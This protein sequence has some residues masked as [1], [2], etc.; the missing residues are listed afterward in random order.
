MKTRCKHGHLLDE[1]NRKWSADRWY[2]G[3]CKRT[4]YERVMKERCANRF[5]LAWP[6]DLPEKFW[7][8]VVKDPIGA[9]PLATP[10]WRWTGSRDREGYGQVSIQG[11]RWKATEISLLLHGNLLPPEGCHICHRCDQ[12]EC[13]RRS[14]LFLGTPA[15]NVRDMDKKGRA[16]WGRFKTQTHCARGHEFTPQN[17]YR[18]SSANGRSRRACRACRKIRETLATA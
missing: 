4:Q 7:A 10:C 17:T 8:R 14:H 9:G 15:D 13:V 2:C 16:R 6:I 1:G 5:A 11:V 3:A 12:P 18:Y